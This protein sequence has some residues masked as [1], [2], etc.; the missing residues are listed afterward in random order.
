MA[1]E[2]K[3]TSVL[4]VHPYPRRSARSDGSEKDDMKIA[5]EERVFKKFKPATRC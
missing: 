4:V 5:E 2:R 1:T 3:R